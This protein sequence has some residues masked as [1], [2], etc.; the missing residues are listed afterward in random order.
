MPARGRGD[1][2]PPLCGW[3]EGT[4]VVKSGE[5]DD[6]RPPFELRFSLSEDHERLVEVVNFTGGRSGGF[7]ASREWDRLPQ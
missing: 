4:L 3:D 7:T 2:A 6:D 1:A 5:P